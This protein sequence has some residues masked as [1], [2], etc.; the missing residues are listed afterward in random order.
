MEAIIGKL[1][2]FLPSKPELQDKVSAKQRKNVCYSLKRIKGSCKD[3]E[4]QGLLFKI[5]F[6]G[7]LKFFITAEDSFKQ[8]F[9]FKIGKFVLRNS[10]KLI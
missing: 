1:C 6:Y 7:Q 10:L 2:N 5:F 3:D 4:L 8:I 9:H